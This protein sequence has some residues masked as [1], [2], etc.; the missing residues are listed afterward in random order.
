VIS[1][2]LIKTFN[3]KEKQTMENED[4]MADVLQQMA[5]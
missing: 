3:M 5:V 2:L 1:S 4:R